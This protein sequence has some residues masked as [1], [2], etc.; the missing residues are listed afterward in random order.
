MCPPS[1]NARGLRIE[2]DA[3]LRD[4]RTQKTTMFDR[5]HPVRLG[6]RE[7]LAILAILAT[8]L[9][10]LNRPLARGGSGFERAKRKLLHAREIRRATVTAC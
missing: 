7:D 4:W 8:S 3:T 6:R 2:Y 9:E 10:A 5:V 1:V